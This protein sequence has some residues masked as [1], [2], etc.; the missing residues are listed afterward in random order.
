VDIGKTDGTA[1]G[2]EKSGVKIPTRSFDEVKPGSTSGAGRVACRPL[3]PPEFHELLRV[4]IVAQP[5]P[6]RNFEF[7]CG[8]LARRASS[9]SKLAMRSRC[10]AEALAG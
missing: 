6:Q 4:A 3:K 7:L 5:F 9:Y 2:F 1:K 10:R 8:T